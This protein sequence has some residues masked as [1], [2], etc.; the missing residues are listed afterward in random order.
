MSRRQPASGPPPAAATVDAVVAEKFGPGGIYADESLFARIY[1]GEFGEQY[2]RQ[3]SNYSA[4]V[5]ACAR[6][7]CT[8]IFET[9]GRFPAHC[10]AIHVPGIWLQL[11]HVDVGYYQRFFR[12][13]LTDVHLNH[14][15]DWHRS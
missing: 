4:D 8:Y 1:R 14:A 12:N 10:D 5:I 2:L 3:A 15:R 6:D 7:I 11:H 9:H 13:G